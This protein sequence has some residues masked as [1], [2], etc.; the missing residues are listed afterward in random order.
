MPVSDRVLLLPPLV[1]S[2]LLLAPMVLATSTPGFYLGYG[3]WIAAPGWDH[4]ASLTVVVWWAAVAFA[5][6]SRTTPPMRR[7]LRVV[8][9]LAACAFASVTVMSFLIA[10]LTEQQVL[11]ALA[12]V[13]VWSWIASVLTTCW[14]SARG[15]VALTTGNSDAGATLGAALLIFFAPVGV[16]LL[17]KRIVKLLAQPRAS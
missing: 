5:V 4:L 15:I 3:T 11:M 13:A 16:W 9:A 1:A 6:A 12:R 10:T 7:Q 17:R 14:F 8:L 2:A